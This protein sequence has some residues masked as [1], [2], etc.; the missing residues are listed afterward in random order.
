M[1]INKNY[2]QYK[3]QTNNEKYHIILKNIVFKNYFIT[4]LFIINKKNKIYIIISYII[5]K[6]NL[7]F[8][9]YLITI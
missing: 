5:I 8:N 2:T 9:R 3:H 6:I 7:I 1:L 4:Y